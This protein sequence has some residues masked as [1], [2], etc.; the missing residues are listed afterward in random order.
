MFEVRGSKRTRTATELMLLYRSSKCSADSPNLL[1]RKRVWT[2]ARRLASIIELPCL[3]GS[4]V[5]QII[6]LDREGYTRLAGHEQPSASPNVGQAFEKG[7]RSI[8]IIDMDIPCGPL[9]IGITLADLGDWDYVTGITLIDRNGDERIIG[10]RS[11]EHETICNVTA[12]QGFKVAMGLGGVRALQVIG[13]GSQTSRWV[14]RID[15][16]PRSE[17][18][19]SDA[20]IS[21]LSVSL[22]VNEANILAKL[23]MLIIRQG[24]KV[25]A[26]AVC[27]SQPGKSHSVPPNRLSLWQSAIWYPDIPSD[28][29][30]LNE[31]SFTGND[32]LVTNYQPLSW[33]HIGG[34]TGKSLGDVGGILVHYSYGLHGL[35]FVYDEASRGNDFIELGRCRDREVPIFPIDGAGGERI[36]SVSVGIHRYEFPRHGLIDYVEVSLLRFGK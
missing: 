5:R 4:P 36:N 12:L 35:K 33:M 15:K 28:G 6:S 10:Y 13:H 1:N 27:R 22:D 24:Y 30:L 9:K 16:V 3:S 20:P 18:L 19:R 32:P 17:R 8:M 14:G 21:G 11:N 7:C 34:E 23:P 26:L 31:D 2:L 29:L 25:T